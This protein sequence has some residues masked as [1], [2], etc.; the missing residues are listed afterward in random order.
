M[1]NTWSIGRTWKPRERWSRP[2]LT[3]KR[4]TTPNPVGARHHTLH[5]SGDTEQHREHKTRINDSVHHP[6]PK[7]PAR[8]APQGLDNRRFAAAMARGRRPVPFRTR[9]LRP[10]TAMVLHPTECGRVARRRNTRT[11]KPD[12]VEHSS[13]TGLS[14]YPHQHLSRKPTQ[15]RIRNAIRVPPTNPRRRKPVKE[16]GADNVNAN[17]VW[18]T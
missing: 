1:Q 15:G 13:P 11:R 17:P 2:V 8:P 14:P 10:C 7:P 9:K 16:A 12:G 4:D 6:V 5:A 3:G 18:A